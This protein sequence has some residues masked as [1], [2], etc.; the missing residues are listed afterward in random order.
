LAGRPHADEWAR[1]AAAVAT[2]PLLL[3]VAACPGQLVD[4]EAFEV[5]SASSGNDAGAPLTCDQQTANLFKST[6]AVGGCHSD[7]KPQ[8]G[9]DLESPNIFAR[10]AGR[11]AVGDNGK[12]VII[13]RGGNAEKSILYLKLISPPPFGLLMPVQAIGVPPLDAGTI[14]CVGTWIADQAAAARAG[15]SGAAAGDG[16]AG[17]SADGGADGAADSSSEGTGDAPVKMLAPG[18]D[19]GGSE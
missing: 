3:S 1:R 10:L 13:D 8:K 2:A 15:S 14:N 5:E 7:K 19:A 18:V 4:R 12:G 6:C 16:A 11:P 9:L 17:S